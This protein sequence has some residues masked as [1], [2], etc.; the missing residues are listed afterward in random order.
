MVAHVFG[1]RSTRF[2]YIS[3]STNDL[4]Q[5]DAP[6]IPCVCVCVYVFEY[7]WSAKKE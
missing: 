2:V 7:V 6:R 1:S 3:R 4:T 5:I